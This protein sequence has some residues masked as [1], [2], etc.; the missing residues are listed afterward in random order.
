MPHYYAQNYAGIMWT[1]LTANGPSCVDQ[2]RT[3]LSKRIVFIV[4]QLN[5][6]D[7]LNINDLTI[8]DSAHDSAPCQ[9]GN[10][11]HDCHKIKIE[12]DIIDK[13]VKPDNNLLVR[14]K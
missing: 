6:L 14:L 13:P 4:T 1:T 3:S 7:A 11:D 5:G 10:T 12:H 2:E 9:T 8:P